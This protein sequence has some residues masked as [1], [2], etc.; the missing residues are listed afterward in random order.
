MG[1]L[2]NLARMTSVTTG[3][4]TLTLGSA[5][6]GCLTFA[7]AGV[8]N[9]EVVSYGISDGANSEVGFGTYTSSGTTLART[10]ILASTNSGNAISCSGS[11][12][13]FITVLAEDVT[14]NDGWIRVKD[15]WAYASATTIT[16]PAGAASRYSVGDKIKLTQ[17]TAKYFYV[18]SIA[19]TVL[20]VTGGTDYTVANA[21]ITLPYYSKAASP[22]GFPQWFN[23][24]PTLAVSG[25]TAPTY[26]ATFTNKFCIIGRQVNTIHFW[27]NSSGGTAG[28]GTNL[29]SVTLPVTGVGIAD[30]NS[31]G[32]GY[33]IEDSGTSTIVSVYVIDT[34]HISFITTAVA[35]VDGD[36]QSSAARGVYFIASYPI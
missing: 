14:R 31:I 1:A 4:G 19:D 25:G 27:G 18:V 8:Q 35:D 32:S 33:V 21:A 6:S 34:T 30:G 24:T 13:V 36:D 29:I 10:T 26:T 15:T 12:Q 22:V 11:Q 5:V 16:V 2:Y 28:A 17:T 9:A 23:Y 3:T 20:T 7:N